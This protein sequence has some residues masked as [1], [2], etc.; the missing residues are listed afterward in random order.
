M[1]H[2]FAWTGQNK[3]KMMLRGKDLGYLFIYLEEIEG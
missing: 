3:H 2:L 1:Q